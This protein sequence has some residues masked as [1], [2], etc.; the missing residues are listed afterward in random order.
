[1]NT[2]F[3]VVSDQQTDTLARLTRYSSELAAHDEA[4]RL[5]ARFPDTCFFVCRAVSASVAPKPEV[6]TYELRTGVRE[7]A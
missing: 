3:L 1:V 2:F 5:A 7:I 4:R 6:H